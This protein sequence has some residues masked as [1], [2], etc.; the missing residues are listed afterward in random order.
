MTYM[1]NKKKWQV[2]N[3]SLIDLLQRRCYKQ[4]A[5]QVHLTRQNKVIRTGMVVRV[6]SNLPALFQKLNRNLKQQTKNMSISTH[7]QSTDNQRLVKL[8]SQQQ[9]T[10]PWTKLNP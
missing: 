1:L 8:S 7:H 3:H 2:G 10:K 4:E 9:I 6:Y 5:Q